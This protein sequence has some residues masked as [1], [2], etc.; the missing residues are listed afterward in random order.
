VKPGAV[1]TGFTALMLLTGC[2]ISGNGS[3]EGTTTGRDPSHLFPFGTLDG[4]ASKRWLAAAAAKRPER[5]PVKK[6][7]GVFRRPQKRHESAIAHPCSMAVGADNGE[8]ISGLRR[9]LLRDVG[10]RRQEL[11]A[12]PTASDELNLGL[13]PDGGADCRI[14]P[15][16][17]D[18]LILGATLE[19]DDALVY[20]MVGDG[21]V[22]VDLVVDGALH[23]ARLGENAFAAVIPGAIDK[24]LERMILRRADGSVTKFPPG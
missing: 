17:T 14:T 15:L 20:G 19:G 24:A 13:T 5:R 3:D 7:Y 1:V 23:H 8:P 12:Q 22:S 6:V 2:S 18:G 9:I 16:T 10:P 11:M 4:A 21:V